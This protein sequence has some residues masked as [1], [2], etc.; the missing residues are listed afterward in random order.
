M[1]R[2][3]LARE[4]SS[5]HG[6]IA[7]RRVQLVDAFVHELRALAGD[8]P[9]RTELLEDLPFFL[10]DLED[11]LREAEGTRSGDTFRHTT[12]HAGATPS[13]SPAAHAHGARRLRMGLDAAA[14]AREYATLR[15]C[16]VRLADEEGV[17]PSPRELELL[18]T[19]IE[20]AIAEA[21]AAYVRVRDV[22]RE[23][24]ERALSEERE[25]L[26]A[27]VRSRDEVLAIVSH[28]LRT[29]LAAILLD[30]DRVRRSAEDPRASAAAEAIVRSARRMDAL[31]RDLLVNATADGG[32]LEVDL[33]PV[34]VRE[35]VREATEL[36][37]GVAESKA[38][39]VDGAACDALVICD[40]ARIL[41][42]LGNLLANAVKHSPEGCVVTLGATRAGPSVVLTVDDEGPGIAAEDLERIFDRFYRGDRR[43]GEGAGLGLAIARSIVDAH[44]GRIWAENREPTGARLAFVLSALRR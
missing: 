38:V 22:E 32:R 19:C 35:L 12:G 1:D 31:I 30:A 6:F 9:T 3:R 18:T 37:R 23:A 15:R 11:A 24:R 42:V 14:L 26:R 8:G 4:Q 43:V 28:D 39:R 27:A 29:P 21:I 17:S 10:A 34:D 7:A 2:E 16:I 40:R 36:V 44:G 41:Q 5:L 20:E 13:A 25:H 33:R